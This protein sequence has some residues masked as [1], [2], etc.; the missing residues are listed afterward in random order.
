MP[1]HRR[2]IMS[3]GVSFYYNYLMRNYFIFWL[4]DIGKI[5]NVASLFSEF[6]FQRNSCYIPLFY[7]AAC[8]QSM[9]IKNWLYQPI[10][11]VLGFIIIYSIS[12]ATRQR[13]IGIGL[14]RSLKRI[15][16]ESK[17]RK[18]LH[19]QKCKL[20]YMKG[21]SHGTWINIWIE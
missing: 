13:I 15:S 9:S 11:V 19:K 12:S 8:N 20:I 3:S 10:Y 14:F 17:K 18:Y 7:I 6:S 5:E 4:Q 1:N 16:S 2:P 21:K